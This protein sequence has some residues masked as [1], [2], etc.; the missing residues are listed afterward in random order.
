VTALADYIAAGSF[1]EKVKNAA[2]GTLE[3]LVKHG[4]L[5]LA[6]FQLC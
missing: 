4:A 2:A 1:D 5:F 6:L 3:K